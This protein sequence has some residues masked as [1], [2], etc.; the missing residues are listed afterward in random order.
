MAL[1]GVFGRA[2]RN[3]GLLSSGEAF[4]E[5][6][7]EICVAIGMTPVGDPVIE[8]FDH[9]AVRA[10][11]AVIFLDDGTHP[12]G[13][14][15]TVMQGLEQSAITGHTYPEDR[16]L[17]VLV[18]SCDDIPHVVALAEGIVEK[19][20]LEALMV[21]YERGWG[22]KSLKDATPLPATWTQALADPT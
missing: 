18:D 2:T 19:W 13:P 12:Q 17:S 8:Q 3:Q 9:W 1:F 4:A 6:L 15:A 14:G 7:R 5:W 21:V 22:W 11:S 16:M 20:G 10:P